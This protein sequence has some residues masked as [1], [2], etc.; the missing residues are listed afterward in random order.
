[1]VRAVP[2]ETLRTS[3]RVKNLTDR[4]IT[5]KA[6]HIIVPPAESYLD[7]VQCFCFLQQTLEPGEEELLPVIFR[8]DY[9]VPDD[10]Q[11]MKVRYEFYPADK[12]PQGNKK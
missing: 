2:G 5:G 9:E 8:V 4:E 12:F 1:M 11:Q 3:Y 7:I 6:R 10:V